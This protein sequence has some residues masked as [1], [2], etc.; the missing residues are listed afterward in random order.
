MPADPPENE[1]ERVRA[2]MKYGLLPCDYKPAPEKEMRGDYPDVPKYYGDERSP[3][4]DWDYPEL[5]LNY[6]EPVTTMFTIP[7]L[8]SS[9]LYELT[10]RYLSILYP[11]VYAP[12]FS[13][14]VPLPHVPRG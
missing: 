6:G 4:T 2:A 14:H 11:S 3:W 7:R 8:L 1:E 9:L 10:S 5:R 13:D 12:S